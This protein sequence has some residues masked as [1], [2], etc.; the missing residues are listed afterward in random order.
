MSKPTAILTPATDTQGILRQVAAPVLHFN[1]GLLQQIH[2]LHTILEQTIA[3]L[4]FGRAMAAPQAGISQRIIVMN[5]GNQDVSLP[6]TLIN[7][8]IFWRSADTQWVWD[9]CLSTP[10]VLV[11]I[12]RHLSISVRYQDCN[13][14]FREWLQLPADLAEL[15]QHECEHLDG[16][17]MI[18][19]QS[20]EKATKVKSNDL[21]HLKDRPQP[22]RLSL[23]AIAQSCRVIDPEFTQTPLLSNPA[24]SNIFNMQLWLK[25]ET[26]NAIRCFKGRGA[27]HFLAQLCQQNTHTTHATPQIVCAS[28]GNWGLAV[29]WSCR[30]RGL[31]LTVFVPEHANKVKVAKIREQ[32]ANIVFQGNDFDS[33]KLAAKAHAKQLTQQAQQPGL[34]HFL[35]DG[36]QH[37]I[38]EGAGS[39]GVELTNSDQHFDAIVVPVGNGALING[40]ARWIKAASPM[41]KIIGVVPEGADSMYQSW[42]QNTVIHRQQ[43]NTSADGLAVRI[44]IPE[45]VNDMSGMIDHMVLVSEQQLEQALVLA[46]QYANMQLEPSGGAALAGLLAI[47][48]DEL[49]NQLALRNVALLITGA[50]KEE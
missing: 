16:I 35:E 44:P 17:L 19:H 31:P 15:I 2:K 8:E 5:L 39:I 33:A 50:N 1:H 34:V 42:K 13:G 40:I 26:A 48:E 18:D 23:Q 14:N 3:T 27:D 28:A 4:G 41:T 7:P 21:S 9:D 22:H 49:F 20:A 12:E 11:Q 45:A 30:K 46:N 38:T 32:G 24:L 25:D 10:E 47:R 37:A 6:V 43:V 29:A 36:K